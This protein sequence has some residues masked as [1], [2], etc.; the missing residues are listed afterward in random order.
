LDFLDFLLGPIGKAQG[1]ASNQAGLYP[2]EDIVTAAFSF[3]NGALA[4]GTWCFTTGAVSKKEYTVL[5]GSKG[6]I[7]Y[8]SLGDAYVILES[9][10]GGKER[11]DFE[12]PKHIQYNLIESIVKELLG[13]GKCPSTGETAQRTNRVMEEIFKA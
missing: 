10:E 12:L 5:A 9:D 6:Q 3:E 2:A 8:P 13:E 1:I 4:T 7:V 11:F